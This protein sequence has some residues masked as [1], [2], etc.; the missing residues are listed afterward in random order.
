MVHT[1][2][3]FL[4][5]DKSAFFAVLRENIDN[6]FETNQL[7]K[8]GNNSLIL[9]AFFML[10]LYLVPYFLIIFGNFSHLEQLGLC[11][12]MGLGIAGVGMSVMHDAVHGSFSSN[13]TI[14][15][16]FGGSLYLLG[17]NVYNWDM[18]HNKLHHTYTNIHEIDED[19]TGKFLLRL[20]YADK[21]KSVHRFQHIY[22]FFLYSLMTISFLWKDFKEIKLYNEMA[23]SGLMKP[24]PKEEYIRLFFGK[25]FYVLFICVIPMMRLD[26]SFG[27]WFAAFMLINFTSGL[28]L[29]TV[30]QAAHIV[31]GAHHPVPDEKGNI[32]NAWAIHQL[33]T[34]ANFANG[35]KLFSWYIGGLDYQVEHHLFPN[36]SHVHYPKI[37]KIVEDTANQFNI[38]YN[39][40]GTFWKAITSHA[41]AL[42]H[43]GYHQQQAA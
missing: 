16:I 10:S 26:I 27:Q 17:G 11:F 28:I 22:A 13:K 34:T 40:K 7:E 37:A 31:E 23:K 24:F 30:F 12:V 39:N 43:L 21:L 15:E 2:V 3:K 35:N 9:K 25:L 38:P 5:K 29:S 8:T 42:K 32:D 36:I 20:N 1:K 33:L 41:K 4:N 19:V 6:Y 14:N 18:Q